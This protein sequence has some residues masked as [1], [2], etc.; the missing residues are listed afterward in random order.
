MIVETMCFVPNRSRLRWL[1]LE[2][3]IEEEQSP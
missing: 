3:K 1:T 2:Y